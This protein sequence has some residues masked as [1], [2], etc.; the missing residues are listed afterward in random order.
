MDHTET[1]EGAQSSTEQEPGP[2][3]REIDQSSRLRGCSQNA[4]GLWASHK[5]LG[6]T[7]ERFAP[8]C[9]ADTLEISWG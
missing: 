1:G 8:V 4:S 5:D 6:S 2:G 7:E 9:R 3:A